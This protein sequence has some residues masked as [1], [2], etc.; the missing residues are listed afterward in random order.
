MRLLVIE[1]DATLRKYLVR[2]LEEEGFVVDGVASASEGRSQAVTNDY[3]GIVVDLDLP[4]GN[5]VDVIREVRARGSRAP[6]MVFTGR[7]DSEQVIEAL[8]AGADDY[9]TKPMGG[10]LIRARVRALVRRGQLNPQRRAP[11]EPLR[12]GNISLNVVNRRVTVADAP[13]QLTPK[14]TLLLQQFMLR[15]GEVVSRT[16]LLEK[17]WDMHFDPDSNV[18][19]TH[20]SRLRTKLRAGGSTAELK[21]VRATGFLL[22]PPA[23]G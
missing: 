10:S 23:A 5:G 22:E 2:M 11:H 21:G 20:V 19:D 8:D 18:V 16:E 1:D 3:D 6:V 15:P 14:E 17:V 7:T 13:L 9:V 12:V 4:D